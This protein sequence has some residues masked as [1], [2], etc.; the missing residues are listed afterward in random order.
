MGFVN[1]IDEES[2]VYQFGYFPVDY[3]KAQILYFQGKKDDAM[4]LF[5]LAEVML[6]KAVAR[7]PDE[8]SILWVLGA[9]QAY[10]GQTDKAA[11]V[12]ERVVDLVPD[13]LDAMS[14]PRYKM[15]AAQIYAIT[16][17]HEKA[18]EKLDVYLAGIHSLWKPALLA[19]PY[20]ASL[21]TNP[22]FTAVLDKYDY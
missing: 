9:T 17:Q 13:S 3:L 2:I 6:Q 15:N 19:D 21:H 7:Q 14:A 12:A 20:F 8:P 4:P 11:E 5:Q 1:A 10:L 22:D 18:L 16:G